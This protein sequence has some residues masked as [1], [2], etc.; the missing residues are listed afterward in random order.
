MDFQIEID[1][2]TYYRETPVE[3]QE[4]TRAMEF[5]GVRIRRY[6]ATDVDTE[7]GAA[8]VVEAILRWVE[9]EKANRG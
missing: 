8:R 3:A 1:G 9:K 7:E 4:R 6:R 5:E 2:D